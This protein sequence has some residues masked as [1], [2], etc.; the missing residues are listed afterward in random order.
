MR[1]E[2]QEDQHEMNVKRIWNECERVWTESEREREERDKREGHW[3][4]QTI[5]YLDRSLHYLI[6]YYAYNSYLYYNLFMLCSAS[7]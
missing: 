3:R 5:K 4:N 7:A 2:G 6:L 1:E